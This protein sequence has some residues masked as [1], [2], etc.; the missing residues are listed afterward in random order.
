[1]TAI[2]LG[3]QGWT[4][5]DWVGVFYP[6]YARQETL[7]PFYAQVFDTVELDSTFYGPPKATIARSWA[8]HTP[9]SFR[10]AAKAP[11]A[12][13]HDKRLVDAGAEM[14]ELARGLEPLGEK[15]GPVLVQLPPDF[16]RDPG[17]E[18]ALRAFLA[19]APAAMRFAV[20]LRHATWHVPA[21]L[22]L[23]RDRAAALAWI[24]WRDLPVWPEIT[25]PFLYVRWLGT[26]EDI[27]RYDRVQI[28]R[29]GELDAWTERVRASIGAVDEIYGYVNN[30]YAGHSPETVRELQSRLGLAVPDPRELWPQRE[31]FGGE[32]R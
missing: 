31:L 14:A 28:D 11:R 26:R 21:T 12:V 1:M 8:R 16:A 23:L 10:F 9:A 22:D 13:T 7:L 25:A 20:E 18:S 30:H 32:P 4:Y 19:A 27:T 24:Q 6:P 3:C 2:R 15:L 17:T 29:A 5:P